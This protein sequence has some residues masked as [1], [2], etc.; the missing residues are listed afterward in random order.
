MDIDAVTLAEL[1]EQGVVENMNGAPA[2]NEWVGPGAPE[3]DKWVGPGAP[4]PQDP[5]PEPAPDKW[6]GPGSE[7]DDGV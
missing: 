7:P 5:E 3:P 6:V 2:E 1:E 4:K